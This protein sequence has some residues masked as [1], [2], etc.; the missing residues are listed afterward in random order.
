MTCVGFGFVELQIHFDDAVLKVKHI[1]LFFHTGIFFSN[2]Y[3]YIY[4]SCPFV[5][6]HITHNWR[7]ATAILLYTSP[8]ASVHQVFCSFID[9]QSFERMS[10]KETSYKTK[11]FMLLLIDHF[12]FFSF[13]LSSFLFVFLSALKMP[14]CLQFWKFLCQTFLKMKEDLI[15]DHQLFIYIDFINTIII[16]T[17]IHYHCLMSIV[18][19]N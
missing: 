10:I 17:L 7:T 16:I 12:F 8:F 18:Y 2:I 19:K 11:I 13:F 9:Y 5:Y 3:I 1:D 15:T 4:I 14:A 6:C